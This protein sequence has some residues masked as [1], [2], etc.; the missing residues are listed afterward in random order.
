MLSVDESGGGRAGVT[1]TVTG[2]AGPDWLL[3]F[4]STSACTSP[5]AWSWVR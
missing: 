1:W 5:A 2:S 4:W 3:T